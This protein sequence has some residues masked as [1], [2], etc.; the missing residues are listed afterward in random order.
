MTDT[1]QAILDV[2]ARMRKI[3]TYTEKL[4]QQDRDAMAKIK[5]LLKNGEKKRAIIHLKQKK[6]IEKEVEKASGA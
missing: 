2:K 5:E 6:F 4:E 1:D 3:R